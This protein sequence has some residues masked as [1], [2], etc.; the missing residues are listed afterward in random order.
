MYTKSK[1]VLWTATLS[2]GRQGQERCY[3]IIFCCNGPPYIARREG[4]F[5]TTT[6]VIVAQFTRSPSHVNL[7][8][9]IVD[10]TV[11]CVTRRIFS[12]KPMHTYPPPFCTFNL[13]V[14]FP[15]YSDNRVCVW[16]VEISISRWFYVRNKVVGYFFIPVSKHNL[17]RRDPVR[18]RD[19]V[20]R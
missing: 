13:P 15:V 16:C 11:A 6:N 7:L 18:I 19:I 8:L 1:Y 5:K 2:T 20:E 12:R 17:L 14:L 9:D 3:S 10:L 4:A